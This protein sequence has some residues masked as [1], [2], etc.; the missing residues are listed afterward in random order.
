VTETGYRPTVID[1][2][3][4]V[5]TP[6][7]I[8]IT[9]AEQL[10]AVLLHAT[11]SRHPVVVDLTGTLFCDSAGLHTLLAAHK[12]AQADGGELRLVLPADGAVPRV[13]TLTGIDR[14]LPCFASLQE[15]LA[16]AP[17]GPDPRPDPGG[18]DM[19]QGQVK[20]GDLRQIR[21]RPVRS[22]QSRG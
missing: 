14:L 2:V 16:T 9:T 17:G 21:A 6:E 1:G 18:P 4:V 10:R 15:A 11:R 8:D 19:D 13:F 7:E 12:R 20:P 22:L 5:A 3:P